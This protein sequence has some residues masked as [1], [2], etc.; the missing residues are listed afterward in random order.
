[1]GWR[2]G[3]PRWWRAGAWVRS[4]CALVLLRGAGHLDAISEGWGPAVAGLMAAHL[5]HAADPAAMREAVAAAGAR[6]AKD[7]RT[8]VGVVTDP[9]VAVEAN[10]EA[11]RPLGQI[12]L[13]R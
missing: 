11:L 8:I 5:D 12:L 10:A 6:A 13:R 7:G 3:I 2:L 4:R 9:A 1:M